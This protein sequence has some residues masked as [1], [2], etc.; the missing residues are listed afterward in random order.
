MS[1]KL[2]L[3]SGITFF[4]YFVFVGI[5]FFFSPFLIAKG[6][7]P[8]TIGYLTSFSFI[9]IIIT[10][11]ILGFLSD[12]LLSNKI[13]LILNFILTILV[14][15]T[16]IITNNFIILAICY[17]LSFVLFI[18]LAPILDGFILTEVSNNRYNIVRGCGSLGAALSFSVNTFYLNTTY[19][20]LILLNI[21][22]ICLMLL[23]LLVFKSST[24][25]QTSKQTKIQ[26]SKLSSLKYLITNKELLFICLLTFLTYGSLKADDA[27]QYLY[28]QNYALLLPLTISIVG[29][30][31]M[32]FESFVMSFSHLLPKVNKWLNLIIA[33]SFLLVIDLLK[34]LF[35]DVKIIVCLSYI[36]I[37]LFIGLFVPTVIKMLNSNPQTILKNTSL[38]LYQVSI[39][40]GGGIL[41]FITT[42]YLKFNGFLPNIYFL[43]ALF[44]GIALIL[45]LGFYTFTKN[46]K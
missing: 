15:L 41:G 23:I 16:L 21:L 32:F 25:V 2:L 8:I 11:F 24:K 7:N 46:S 43:H 29:T 1:L 36:F 38:S 30:L 37:G 10:Y 17:L 39:S 12:K 27:Y 40:L 35:Y 19:L 28:Y 20:N 9:L 18:V 26:L 3:G 13:I 33:I 34:F 4:Y 14:F 42:T 31:S 22:L 6:M 45:V 44:I 5:S